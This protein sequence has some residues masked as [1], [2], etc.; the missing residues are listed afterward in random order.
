MGRPLH[1]PSSRVD[2]GSARG[3]GPGDR[4][5]ETP[6]ARGPRVSPRDRIHDPGGTPSL[7][8]RA[9]G[10]HARTHSVSRGPQ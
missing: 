8:H 9:H 2:E 7:E 4:A 6:Q 1:A 3:T 10:N 5:Q